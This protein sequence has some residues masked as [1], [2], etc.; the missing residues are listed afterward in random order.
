MKK[1]ILIL[2]IAAVF[3]AC[4]N[5]EAV[6][7]KNEVTTDMITNPETASEEEVDMENLPQ[8]EFEE[9]VIEFGEIVQGEKVKRNFVFENT[10]KSALIISNASGSCGCTVPVWPKEPI[11]PGEKGE[12]EVVF[13]SHGKQG[14]QHKTVT[15]VANTVPNTKVIAIKGDVLAPKT[16]NEE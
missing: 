14:R 12:I 2:G 3:V 11:Q 16:T 9:D 13:D 10:G 15:L 8:F 1:T 4:E 7:E 6:E 5:K